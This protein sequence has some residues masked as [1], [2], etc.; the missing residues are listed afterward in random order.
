MKPMP[1]VYM[2]GLA[3]QAAAGPLTPPVGPV[4]STH[5]T[6]T[7]I[8]PR[9]AVNSTNTPGDGNSVFRISVPGS[10]YLAANVAGEVGKAGIE[11]AA[12]NVTLD[13]NG[14]EIVGITGALTGINAGDFPGVGG[15]AIRNGT[16]R[17][18]PGDAVSFQTT[19]VASIAC[20][21]ENLTA[22]DNGGIGF[23]CRD[24]AIMVACIAEG[25]AVGFDTGNE[26]TISNCAAFGNTDDGFD[27][28]YG[29][30]VHN[31]VARDNG[32][33]G[34]KTG[35]GP[36]SFVGCTASS[37]DGDGFDALNSVLSA[38][39]A[40]F[41]SGF[42]FRVGNDSTITACNAQ[43]SAASAGGIHATGNCHIRDNNVSGGVAGIEVAG[44]DCRI[45]GNNVADATTG[46]NIT[47]T[48][49]LV[50][51]N[52]ASGGTTRY[53]IVAGN[54][55]GPIVAAANVPTN[56]IPTANFDY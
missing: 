48:G 1:L 13:L 4:A 56:Q 50:I 52:S 17:N 29:S 53:N 3:A 10:Y 36:V 12:E 23:Q 30:T 26:A 2:L 24:A 38:C 41:N 33:D 37:N 40:G 44:N 54:A 22:R 51:R 42:A 7:D 6:L 9:T 46:F 49:N 19:R 43:T 39:S 27:A 34:F 8:E 31:C 16:I 45:E 14:F 20:R 35:N 28:G 18:W 47:G 25:N 32:D 5:K 21:F 55:A 15:A 11:I